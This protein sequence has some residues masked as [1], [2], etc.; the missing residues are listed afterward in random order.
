MNSKPEHIV[1]LLHGIRT[2]AEWV[3]KAASI[4]NA[5][6]NITAKP[7]KY[8]YFDLVRFLLPIPYFRNKAIERIASLINDAFSGN[9]KHVSIIAHSFGTYILSRILQQNPYIRF[10]RTIL[11]GGIIPE[12]YEWANVTHKLE[13]DTEKHWH[14]INDCG[15]RDIWPVMAKTATWGFGPSGRFGFG[16]TRVKDRYFNFGHSDFFQE[17]FII[18]YWVPYL[19]HGTIVEGNLDRATTPLWASLITIIQIK[20]LAL[21]LLVAVFISLIIHFCTPTTEQ[22]NPI[23]TGITTSIIGHR[24]VTDSE[25]NRWLSLVIEW[26]P[27]RN[28]CKSYNIIG[29][30]I[31]VYD[32]DR[33]TLE[34]MSPRYT[35]HNKN[36]FE[37][38]CGDT[39]SCIAKELFK[40]FDNPRTI[41][42]HTNRPHPPSNRY[43]ADIKLNT[44][45]DN[46]LIYWKFFQS[47]YKNNSRC[48]IDNSIP[49]QP[50]LL[51]ILHTTN[52]QG[53]ITDTK[54]FYNTGTATLPIS[55][56]RQ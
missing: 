47:E 49:P 16:H 13:T 24:I 54:C 23:N 20:Y 33:Y 55:F 26:T 46:I 34:S 6:C 27:V 22:C 36:I 41:G 42:L 19:C 52:K 38:N 31:K 15:M 28:E 48:T 29:G 40:W 30:I 8:G 44:V 25:Q 17:N 45:P 18:K 32:K 51:P 9:P 35:N 21:L 53:E 4:L 12:H 14:A 56:S 10:H 7:I 1:L 3:S 39:N 43:Q 50:N 2:Q 5:E 11:C 37:Y